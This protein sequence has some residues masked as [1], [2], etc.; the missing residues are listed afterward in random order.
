MTDS[1]GNITNVTEGMNIEMG[2]NSKF[3]GSQNAAQS[4][5]QINI[6]LLCPDISDTYIE[7]ALE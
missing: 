2:L 3:F 1:K 4:L 6:D 7:E 5:Y